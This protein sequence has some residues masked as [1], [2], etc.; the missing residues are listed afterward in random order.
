M[1]P[2]TTYSS[3]RG[4]AE[5]GG[6]AGCLPEVE[7]GVAYRVARHSDV[8][9][10]RGLGCG[11]IDR[12]PRPDE[13]RVCRGGTGGIGAS[14]R[15]EAGDGALE[16]EGTKLPTDVA[17]REVVALGITFP[18]VLEPRVLQALH[19][20]TV[21]EHDLRRYRIPVRRGTAGFAPLV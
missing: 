18:V 5:V 9:D 6:R 12:Q 14:R 21:V 16:T 7:E 19:E 10:L 1:T 20:G 13:R 4:V 8:A 15:G 17:E 2:S 3:V 11:L